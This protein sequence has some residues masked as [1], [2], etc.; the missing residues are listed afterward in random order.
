[1]ATPTLNYLQK[2]P[3]SMSERHKVFRINSTALR[4]VNAL[5]YEARSPADSLGLSGLCGTNMRSVEN[6]L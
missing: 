5:G 4:V 6:S 3:R 1:M 2:F